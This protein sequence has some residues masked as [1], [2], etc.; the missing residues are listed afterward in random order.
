MPPEPPYGIIW[1]R[2]K[3]VNVVPF[4]GVGASF[5]R[6]PLDTKWDAYNSHF[7]DPM[8]IEDGL[9]HTVLPQVRTGQIIIGKST[10][11]G[12]AQAL[13]ETVQIETPFLQ[14]VMT[15]LGD[16]EM[17]ENS[18]ILRC[19]TLERLGKAQEIVRTHLEGVMERLDANEREVC[20]RF[21]DR[22][23]TPSGSGVLAR[24]ILDWQRQYTEQEEQERLKQ[25]QI[26]VARQRALE[27]ARHLRCWDVFGLSILLILMAALW[28]FAF[29]VQNDARAANELAQR[30]LNRILDSIE[31]KQAVLSGDQTKI[32]D[33]ALKSSLG[34]SQI[35]FRALATPYS[36]NNRQEKPVYHFELF[37]EKN[38]IPGS[39]KTIAL[40]TY[41]IDHPSFSNSLIVAGPARDGLIDGWGCF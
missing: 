29:K 2:L 4:L 18:R 5:V 28:I 40:I 10:G 7:P 22:L 17:K 25:E 39:L 9:V 20:A 30:W 33:A 1:N 21:F 11:S 37:P 41:R 38:S 32:I 3:A 6:R 27:R 34:N 23:V 19:V 36:Y 31:L 13:G 12:Q 16:E 24:A 8:A 26:E 15:R 14:L 35:L